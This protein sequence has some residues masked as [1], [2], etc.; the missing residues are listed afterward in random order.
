MY[1]LDLNSNIFDETFIYDTPSNLF[2][3]MARTLWW[4]AC[5]YVCKIKRD[6]EWV[7]VDLSNKSQH[8]LT[9][10]LKAYYYKGQCYG[11]GQFML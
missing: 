5:I 4:T 10:I 7:T 9:L 6:F 1:K 8:I 3:V 11:N 2:Q